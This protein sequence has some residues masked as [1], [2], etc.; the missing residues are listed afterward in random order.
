[1]E[2]AGAKALGRLLCFRDYSSAPCSGRMTGSR[3]EVS[4][5]TIIAGAVVKQDRQAVGPLDLWRQEPQ[6]AKAA[7]V[8]RSSTVSVRPSAPI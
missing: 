6:I 4:T 3:T 8:S 7:G 1:M 5:Y 2:A